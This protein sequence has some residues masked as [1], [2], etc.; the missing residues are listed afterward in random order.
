MSRRGNSMTTR[1]KA[2]SSP[3]GAILRG[4]VLLLAL[5]P[6]AWA[7]SDD[8]ALT[9][10]PVRLEQTFRLH[11]EPDQTYVFG[12]WGEPLWPRAGT[13]VMKPRTVVP[14]MEHINSFPPS[15]RVDGPARNTSLDAP[16]PGYRLQARKLRRSN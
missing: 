9:P 15:E 10:K 8:N 13:T 4:S 5:A 3:A 7:Q 14:V 16:G 11:L 1:R 6:C 2:N 12:K